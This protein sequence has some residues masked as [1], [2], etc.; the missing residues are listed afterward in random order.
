MIE[1]RNDSPTNVLPFDREKFED[2]ATE[3]VN[4][5]VTEPEIL[6]PLVEA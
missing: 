2:D 6:E 4:E 5:P 1:P 3:L